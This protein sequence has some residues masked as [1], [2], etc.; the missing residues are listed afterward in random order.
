MKTALRFG[1]LGLAVSLV[2][3]VATPVLFEA[4]SDEAP[5]EADGGLEASTDS[6]IAV[7]TS[8]ADA[9]TGC[10]PDP[11]PGDSGISLDFDASARDAA[12]DSARDAVADADPDA[13]D[14][15]PDAS[16]DAAPPPEPGPFDPA[17]SA[18]SFT[19]AQ[20]L[21][22]YPAVDGVLTARIDTELGQIVCRLDEAAAPI[23]VANF[24]GLARGTRPYLQ[25]TTWKF[26]RF[27]DGLLWHRVIPDFVIQ[28]GDPKGNGTGGPGYSLPNENH[29]P[30]VTGVLS[31]AA[32]NPEP[33]VFVPSG[34]QLYIV[35][36]DGPA[37]DYNVFGTCTLDVAKAIAAV[38]RRS[39]DKPKVPIHMTRVSIERC[40][41]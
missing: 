18:A 6:A 36:G 29:A 35:V 11:G 37:N 5:V 14:A 27:Y 34:S 16:T 28:G 32:G 38:E 7:D 25:G 3:L 19:L 24:V 4:C 39:N 20:A 26:G 17:G 31:M 9:S 13:G 10:L 33:D 40:P 21:A 8:I 12:A 1:G 30:Q 2:G 23:T 41:R 15:D 22:G